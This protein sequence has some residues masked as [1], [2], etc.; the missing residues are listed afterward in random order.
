VD[1]HLRRIPGAGG[2][3]YHYTKSIKETEMT[4]N[5]KTTL[6]GVGVILAAIGKA[7]G[8]YIAGDF[9]GVDWNGLALG[10]IAGIG[11]IMAKDAKPTAEA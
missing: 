5:W 1:S 4:M 3:G 2:H 11:L 8:E 10:V 7:I 6:A 9:S